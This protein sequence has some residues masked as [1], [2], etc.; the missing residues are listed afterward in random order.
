LG[1]K[2]PPAEVGELLIADDI[3]C[4]SRVPVVATKCRAGVRG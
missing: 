2:G 3:V 1:R 4:N